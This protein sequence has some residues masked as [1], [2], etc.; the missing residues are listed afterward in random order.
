MLWG[1][2]DSRPRPWAWTGL[3]PG[4]SPLPGPG[5]PHIYCWGRLHTSRAPRGIPATR[6]R[7]GGWTPV[8]GAHFQRGWP[9]STRTATVCSCAPSTRPCR[10]PSVLLALC[11]NASVSP[12]CPPPAKTRPPTA[13]IHA[14]RTSASAPLEGRQAAAQSVGPSRKHT[15]AEVQPQGKPRV[16]AARGPILQTEPGW[17]VQRLVPDPGVIG[18]AVGSESGR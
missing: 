4:C 5:P 12:A 14:L 2:R 9:L 17:G 1:L 13:R 3:E 8:Q 10:N 6:L 16:W 7:D 15:C 18:G 11:P